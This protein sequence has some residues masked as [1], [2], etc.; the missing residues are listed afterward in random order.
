[1]L[2]HISSTSFLFYSCDI[3]TLHPYLSVSQ[4][5]LDNEEKSDNEEVR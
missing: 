4:I 5:K 2:T 3:T 1:M